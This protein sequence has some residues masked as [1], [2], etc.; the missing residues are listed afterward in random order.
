MR[1]CRTG[2]AYCS[3]IKEKQAVD[4]GFGDISIILRGLFKLAMQAENRDLSPD[5]CH[6][7]NRNMFRTC[8]Q[9]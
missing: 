2:T 7:T 8:L 4:Y 9:Q 1:V 6:N 5:F 3:A